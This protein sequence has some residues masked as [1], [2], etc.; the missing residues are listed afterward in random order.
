MITFDRDDLDEL[1]SV[2]AHAQVRNIGRSVAIPDEPST[3]AA[4]EPEP[5]PGDTDE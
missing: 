4:P 3:V 2:R 1:R 5:E